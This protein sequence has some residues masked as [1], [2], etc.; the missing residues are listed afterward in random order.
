M[1]GYYRGFCKNFADVVAP[2]TSLISVSQPFVWSSACQKSFES[3]KAL[4]CSTPVLS[5]PD[6]AHPFKLEVD[7]STR[8]AG[9]VLLHEDENGVDHPVAYFSKKFNQHQLQYSTIEQEALS[10]LLAL[11]HFEVYIGS[12]LLPVLVF[13]DHN[14][15]VFLA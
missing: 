8:G 12:S 10:L 11:Q 1:A 14:R 13:T 5:A 9:A 6:F 3:T 2:L 4:L 7:A 15:L